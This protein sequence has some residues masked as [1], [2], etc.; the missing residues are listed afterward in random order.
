MRWVYGCLVGMLGALALTCPCAALASG[1]TNAGDDLRTGWYPNAAISPE[2]V[3]SGTFG[4]L[5]SASVDG[6]VY[7][8]PL[9][10]T[11]TSGST[12]SET[13]IVA[14]E[15]DHVYGLDPN[16]NGAQRWAVA[17]A[18]P[19]NP[20]DLG[21][22]DIA[23][24][25]GTTSTPV[26][27]P[28]TNTVYLT[29][30]TY[31]SGTSGPA[32]WYMDAL[33]VSTGQQRPGF[34]VLLSGTADND[35]N[36]TFDPTTQQQRPGLL[37]MNGVV[38]AGF[39]SH[40]DTSP[41][42][43]WIMGVSTTTAQVTARWVDDTEGDGAGIW[44]SGVGLMSDGP[45]SILFV[46]GNGGSPTVATPGT[47]PPTSFGDSVVRLDVNAD[48]SLSPVDFFTPFDGPQLDAW[49]AD[50]GSGGI[51]GLPDAYFGTPSIPSLAVA[52]GKEGY[53]YLLNRDDL[54]GFDQGSGGGD[55]VVQRIGPRGGVWGRPGVW[56]GDGGYVYIPTS[57]GQTSG[58]LFDAYQ[59]GV[60]GDGTPSLSLAASASQVFGWGSGSPIITSDGATSGS[61]LVWIIWSPNRTGTGAELEA[62]D[63]VP[64][65]GTLQEVYSAPIGTATNY[66]TPGVGNDGRLYVGTRDGTV[67]AFGSPV[68]QPLA[69]SLPT[70]DATT[71]GS[72]SQQTLTLTADEPLTIS[73]LTSTSS[74]FTLGTPSQSLPAEL[75]TGDTITVP[76]TFSPG[77]STGLLGGDI[78]VD[79]DAAPSVVSIPVSGTGQSAVPQLAGNASLVSLGGTAIGGDLSGT[80]S[81]SN[82][83]NAPLRITSVQLP[84]APFSVTDAPSV[85][86]TIDPGKTVTVDIGFEPTQAGQFTDTI[87]LN[88]TGGE[89]EIGISAAAAPPGVLEFSGD[90]LAFGNVVLGTTESKTFTLT[91][92]GGTD[93]TITKSKPPYGGAFAATT[94]LP[95]GT[96]MT[97]GQEL[98]ETV[99]FTPTGLGPSTGSWAINGD[100]PSGLHV[101]Q[102]T[103]TGISAPATQTTTTP[104]RPPPAPDAPRIV[105]AAP[106][107]RTLARTWITYRALIGGTTH[108]TLERELPGRQ[109]LHRCLRASTRNKSARRCTLF[110]LVARFAHRDHVG[111][112]R[113]SLAAVLRTR[114]LSPGRYVLRSVLDDAG[115][116]GHPFTTVFSV[117]KATATRKADSLGRSL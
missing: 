40:C 73:S 9:V 116:D 49:D 8:Q 50:F 72:S 47:S 69:G 87:T 7:A 105:P 59:Y 71:D 65:E 29:Y 77:T 64:S 2:V 115:G 46:T 70:F 28:T 83:G 44:Q 99:T 78:T 95:E 113:V 25:I 109:D 51:V 79:T 19:W 103:G 20:A 22:A 6:Q 101:L 11:T 60:S 10:A 94:S 38:Y 89:V 66:S 90:D 68:I 92:S 74:Q 62:Y 14:T 84:G 15:T 106:T 17:L 54:G 76:V 93:V 55:G 91:D 111:L 36:A 13:V 1:I 33:D 61:A 32:A 80:V 16:N 67:L 108:F 26:I 112:N 114:R 63:A 85:N 81:F 52:V 37:L 82:V 58:G 102:F 104:V 35:P 23:P 43:G 57:S 18:T 88:S 27:D 107:T 30:K 97:P 53:V 3:N 117:T 96:T 75:G 34:P 24:S 4:Q 86:D 45:G 12:T 42:Q 31:A 100:D 41:W 39:G 110:V 5:W 56:P 98:T 48:G 21:C